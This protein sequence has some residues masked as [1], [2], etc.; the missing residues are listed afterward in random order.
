MELVSLE[1]PQ[2]SGGSLFAVDQRGNSDTA[3]LQPGGRYG[4]SIILC[5]MIGTISTSET[6]KSLYMEL[7]RIFRSL[8]RK[9]REFYVGPEALEACNAGARLTIS[10]FSPSEF[11]LKF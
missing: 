9:Q 6:S 10:A 1:V 4:N 11:N 5:G 3:L 8:F 2:K 7:A